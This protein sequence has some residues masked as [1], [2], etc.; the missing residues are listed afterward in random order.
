MINSKLFDFYIIQNASLFINGESYQI[1]ANNVQYSRAWMNRIK[2]KEKN[3]ILFEFAEEFNKLNLTLKEKALLSTLC[4][5]FPGKFYLNV[6]F[7]N[8][9]NLNFLKSTKNNKEE[10]VKDKEALT[11][12]NEYYTRALLY[13]F[14]LNKRNHEFVIRFGQVKPK[15]YF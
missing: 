8:L 9:K 2:S 6:F 13:E 14:D 3:D 1:I 11:D 5:T 7:F 15:I 4:F 12:I 10:K